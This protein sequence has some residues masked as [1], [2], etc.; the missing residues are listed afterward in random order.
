MPVIIVIWHSELKADNEELI[1]FPFLICY[2]IIYIRNSK[3]NENLMD[4]LLDSN[5]SA[6]FIES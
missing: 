4:L 1:C 5:A 2:S 6:V 3:Q